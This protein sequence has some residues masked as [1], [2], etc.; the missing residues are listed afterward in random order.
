MVDKINELQ[1]LIL[2]LYPFTQDWI[3]KYKSPLQ[4]MTAL[5]PT[6]HR[7]L[8]PASPEKSDCYIRPS[9]RPAS[10]W[11][12]SPRLPPGL[13][14]F[15][16]SV[17]I[18]AVIPLV[19]CQPRLRGPARQHRVMSYWSWHCLGAASIPLL[20]S[21]VSS[22]HNPRYQLHPQPIHYQSLAG[23]CIGPQNLPADIPL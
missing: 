16:I 21:L 19:D 4:N 8:N 3:Q 18:T 22:A 5:H 17:T 1:K 13:G 6:E 23:E 12:P 11:S 20:M 7:V 2:P 14:C 10:P 9:T 15:S